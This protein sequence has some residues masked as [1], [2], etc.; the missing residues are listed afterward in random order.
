[1]EKSVVVLIF[2]DF[3]KAFEMERIEIIM[4]IRR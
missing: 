2:V 4:R 1:M 3:V